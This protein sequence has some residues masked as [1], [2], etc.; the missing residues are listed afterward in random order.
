MKNSFC[1]FKL[2]IIAKNESSQIICDFSC[3]VGPVSRPCMPS[4]RCAEEREK[5]P[6]WW[7]TAHRGGG[8]PTRSARSR[9]AILC[10]ADRNQVLC[11]SK[12]IAVVKPWVIWLRELGKAYR[13]LG[14]EECFQAVRRGEGHVR[15]RGQYKGRREV[16]W[17]DRTCIVWWLQ[18]QKKMM[19]VDRTR[20]AFI[21]SE[22]DLQDLLV[23][24]VWASFN[25]KKGPFLLIV[26]VPL[27][28]QSL[29]FELLELFSLFLSPRLN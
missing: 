5:I 17:Y 7:G 13:G 9:T 25:S 16:A 22:K 11:R 27:S 21:R 4:G 26:V 29:M 20:W 14:F 12:H 8:Q 10:T 24:E 6:A 23:L 28:C 2:I 3:W 19:R 15:E 18:C 1:S